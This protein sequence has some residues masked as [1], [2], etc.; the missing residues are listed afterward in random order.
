MNEA[1]MPFYPPNTLIVCEGTRTEPLYFRAMADRINALYCSEVEQPRVT[2]VGAGKNTRSLLHFARRLA[3]R[4]PETEL[5]WLVYDRDDFPGDDF[6]NTQY[7]A[8]AIA[9]PPHYR[10]AWSNECIELW[11]LLHFQDLHADIGRANYRALLR[12]Y[13][14]YEKNLPDLYQRLAP[15][16]AAAIRRARALL[17]DCGHL[18]PSR[19]CPAT[20]VHELVEFLTAYLT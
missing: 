11:F 13:F 8:A 5:I 14:P 17:A 9:G 16:T 4:R 2:V 3:A 12:R 15:Y 7:A 20:R 19:C 10:V 6:D 18:P 1:A